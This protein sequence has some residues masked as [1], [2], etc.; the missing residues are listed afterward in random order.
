MELGL[1]GS[2]VAGTGPHRQNWCDAIYRTKAPEMTKKNG[3]RN[4]RSREPLKTAMRRTWL[5]RYTVLLSNVYSGPNPEWRVCD[6]Q[7]GAATVLTG[8]ASPCA[9]PSGGRPDDRVD[10][11]TDPNGRRR[12]AALVGMDRGGELWSH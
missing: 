12:A 2:F 1:F 10:P 11:L 8:R 3:Q 5:H 7:S 4:S 9:W 6:N